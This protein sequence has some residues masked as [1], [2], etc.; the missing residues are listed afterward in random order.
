MESMLGGTDP[1]LCYDTTGT[2]HD[3]QQTSDP[4]T[5]DEIRGGMGALEYELGLRYLLDRLCYFSHQ[6]LCK[7]FDVG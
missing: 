2:Y 1:V 7:D 3:V 6:E 4:S 5:A